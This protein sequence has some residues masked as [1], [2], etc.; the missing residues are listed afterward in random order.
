[1]NLFEIQNSV[2]IPSTHALLLEPFKSVWDR[3][4][5]THKSI[6]IKEFTYIEFM[7]SYK[8]S[9]PF[10]G[11]IPEMRKVKVGEIV[12]SNADY[13]PD[14]YIKSA[15]ALYEK[16]QKEASPSMVFV[17]SC[18][19]AVHKLQEFLQ[20][21][22]FDERTNAGSA[23]YKPADVARAIK[24][25]P[26]LLNSIQKM[27]DKVQQELFDSVKTRGQRTVNHFED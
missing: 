20:N 15:M 2:A 14:E 8:K 7:C 18:E 21:V 9:N 24:E 25:A 27:K 12:M 3:D 4:H 11:Y 1:M 16:L 6:A 17:E 10:N 26:E 19:Q 5:S 13:E 23:V 22:D